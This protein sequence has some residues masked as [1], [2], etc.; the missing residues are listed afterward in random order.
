MRG[1]L[2]LDNLLYDGQNDDAIGWSEAVV[3][4]LSEVMRVLNSLSQWKKPLQPNWLK[5]FSRDLT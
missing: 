3:H 2:Y 4:L 5:P 1:N